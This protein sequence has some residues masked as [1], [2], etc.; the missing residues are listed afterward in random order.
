MDLIND[1][2]KKFNLNCCCSGTDPRDEALVTVQTSSATKMSAA[3]MAYAEETVPIAVQV[4]AISQAPQFASPVKPQAAKLTPRGVAADSGGTDSAAGGATETAEQEEKRYDPDSGKTLTFEELYQLF[5]GRSSRAEINN[6][7]ETTM[8]VDYCQES[9]EHQHAVED[10]DQVEQAFEEVEEQP[11]VKPKAKV[12]KTPKMST[13]ASAVGGQSGAGGSSS[14][15]KPEK[16]KEKKSAAPAKVQKVSKAIEA[17]QKAKEGDALFQ[18]QRFED[19]IVVYTAALE[20]DGEC[21]VALCGR[22]GCR[23]RMNRLDEAKQDLEKA[24]SI[25]PNHLLA[26]RDKAEVALKQDDYDGAIAAFDE[27]LRLAPVD[28]KAL[29][30]RADAKLRKGDKTAAITDLMMA[31]RLGYP[32]AQELLAKAKA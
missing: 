8:T 6:Y 18:Q 3:S 22:G 27:K 1:F 11:K 21:I 5:G 12:M 13:A 15:K 2:M 4:T 31:Q 14:S 28:G 29:C 26:L 10:A 30:G 17:T 19:A 20:L 7:W 16:A 32:G 23:L 25:D 24:L 9:Q